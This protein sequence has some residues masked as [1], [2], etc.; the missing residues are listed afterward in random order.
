MAIRKIS[1][2]EFDPQLTLDIRTIIKKRDGLI[3]VR[4]KLVSRFQPQIDALTAQ[5][6]EATTLNMKTF[7]AEDSETNEKVIES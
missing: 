2:T 3:A 7:I 1:D 4:D 6:D 5:I